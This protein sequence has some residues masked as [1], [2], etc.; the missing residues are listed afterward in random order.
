MADSW[1]LDIKNAHVEDDE[2]SHE[3]GSFAVFEHVDLALQTEDFD[4]IKA[5]L[6]Q[7]IDVELQLLYV[8][9]LLMATNYYRTE[10]EPARASLVAYARSLCANQ[11]DADEM[12]DGLISVDEVENAKT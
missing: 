12:L 3:S 4:S 1:L 9:C 11:E 10:C 5:M 7:A 2:L 8:I 6:A